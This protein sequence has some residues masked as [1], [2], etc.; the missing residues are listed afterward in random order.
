MEQTR[1]NVK[2]NLREFYS[3]ITKFRKQCPDLFLTLVIKLDFRSLE[4]LICDMPS[5]C[6]AEN[7]SILARAVQLYDRQRNSKMTYYHLIL[8]LY[9]VIC[10]QYF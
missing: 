8:N 10:Y 9:S 6:Q 5:T 7:N 1:P 4:R 3:G 2:L